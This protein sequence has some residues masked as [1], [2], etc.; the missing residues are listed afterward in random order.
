M[1]LWVAIFVTSMMLIGF[2]IGYIANKLYNRSVPLGFITTL[3]ALIV[4]MCLFLFIIYLYGIYQGGYSIK[5]R[6]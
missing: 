2:V 3:L 1:N 4:P 5:F 6:W